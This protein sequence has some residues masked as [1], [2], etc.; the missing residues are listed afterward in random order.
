[1]RLAATNPHYRTPPK[2]LDWRF[3]SKSDTRDTGRAD[4][5]ATVVHTEKPTHDRE[6]H[7]HSLSITLNQITSETTQEKQ[8]DAKN[9][10][11]SIIVTRPD[12]AIKSSQRFG[13]EKD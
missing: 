1:L 4:Y 10:N 11:E 2:R 6:H 8:R 12:V 7:S 9:G 5:I 3:S 13:L